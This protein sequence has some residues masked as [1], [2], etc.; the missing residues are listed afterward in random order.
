MAIAEGT[1]CRFTRVVGGG[2]EAMASQLA[3]RLNVPVT[4]ARAMI[5]AADL[6]VP[7]EVPAEPV[8]RDLT[9]QAP[10][11]QQDS[12]TTTDPEAATD[13]KSSATPYA[14]SRGRHDGLRVV[15]GHRRAD[16]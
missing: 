4:D 1:V 2:L 10:I 14:E 15:R 6:S 7:V 11:E 16:R 8:T 13:P 3:E 5:A 12:D 9:E